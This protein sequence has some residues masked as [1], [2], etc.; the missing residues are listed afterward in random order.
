MANIS[1]NCYIAAWLLYVYVYT[2]I[3][4]DRCQL[5]TQ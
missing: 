5:N 3:Y 2:Y 4:Y 1:N